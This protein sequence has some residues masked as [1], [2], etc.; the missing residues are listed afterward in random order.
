MGTG[1]SPGILA[2]LTDTLARARRILVLTGAGISAESGIPTFREAG[3]G[4]WAQYN[5]LELA[6]PEAFDRDPRL[7]WSWYQWRRG[8]IRAADPNP[9][10]QALA[11]MQALGL[12]V[13]LV[14]QN[15]DGL[16]QRAGF[17]G[18]VEF[19]G[20]IFRNRCRTCGNVG[21]AGDPAAEMPPRCPA[22]D[23]LM[24]PGVVWFGE[25]IPADALRAADAA[26]D[27][28]DVFLSV[29]TSALVAPASSLA[30]RAR[31]GGAAI[32]EINPASTDLTDRADYAL[33]GPAGTL[34]PALVS[35][36]RSR[37][38]GAG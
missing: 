17:E 2:E 24:G 4:F 21:R 38:P 12:P 32:A 3:T 6:T 33:A 16:H 30:D 22:C 8:L 18:V 36:L 23:S 14:T 31:A 28:C 19:H 34:L 27:E 11:A 7:V 1:D 26:A 5:P 35:G 29:G 10:H 15:V 13:T 25:A 20:N 37:D 9:G